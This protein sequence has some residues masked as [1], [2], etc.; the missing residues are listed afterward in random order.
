MLLKKSSF[1]KTP[2]CIIGAFLVYLSSEIAE[3]NSFSSDWTTCSGVS[4]VITDS[5]WG[6]VGVVSGSTAYSCG[7]VNCCVWTGC[8]WD[9][10]CCV[11]SCPW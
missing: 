6:W 3:S 8:C 4:V 11:V 5:C 10:A 7:W 2:Q 1:L 9:C